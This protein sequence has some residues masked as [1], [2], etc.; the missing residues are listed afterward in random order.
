MKETSLNLSRKCTSK[1]GMPL[2]IQV[3]QI[4]LRKGRDLMVLGK[5]RMRARRSK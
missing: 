5:E 4:I 1:P 2:G 3:A